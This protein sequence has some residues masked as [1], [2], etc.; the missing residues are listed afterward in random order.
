MFHHTWLVLHEWC[1]AKRHSKIRWRPYV[2]MY[3][4]RGRSLGNQSA[5]IH[6]AWIVPAFWQHH[7]NWN[8]SSIWEPNSWY[9][10]RSYQPCLA[11]ALDN[12][13]YPLNWAIGETVGHIII[14]KLNSRCVPSPW[15]S[16]ACICLPAS[17]V[18]ISSIIH[19]PLVH[20]FW[21]SSTHLKV[22]HHLNERLN[23]LLICWL[24][25]LGVQ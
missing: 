17:F 1:W 13:R 24:A 18:Q 16:S 3:D 5:V 19:H 10:Q 25:R 12:T 14:R 23:M 4:G 8:F 2:I 6:T 11:L 15:L 21:T 9:C 7:S 22:I 20:P